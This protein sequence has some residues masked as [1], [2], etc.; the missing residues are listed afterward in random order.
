MGGGGTYLYG[1]VQ[2]PVY[3]R[4]NGIQLVSDTNLYVGVTHSIV[5]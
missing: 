5:R 1:L 3:Q 2:I 4:V